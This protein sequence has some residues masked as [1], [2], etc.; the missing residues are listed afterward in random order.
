MILQ[1]C[2]S[3]LVQKEFRNWKLQDWSLFPFQEH[4]RENFSRVPI[5]G[6][7]PNQFPEREIAKRRTFTAAGKFSYEV[8]AVKFSREKLHSRRNYCEFLRNY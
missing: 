3:P 2:L 6:I 5:L 1:F 8:A 7:Y 4:R